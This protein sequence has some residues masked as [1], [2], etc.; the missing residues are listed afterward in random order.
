MFEAKEQTFKTI[1]EKI[2]D[3]LFSRISRNLINK[4]SIKILFIEEF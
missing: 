2:Y 1:Y 4:Q 3:K